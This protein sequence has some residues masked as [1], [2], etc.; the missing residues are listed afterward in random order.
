[1]SPVA[2]QGRYGDST[3]FK[4]IT[5]S[6]N[7]LKDIEHRTKFPSTARSLSWYRDQHAIWVLYASPK[8]INKWAVQIAKHGQPRPRKQ[9][10][11]AGHS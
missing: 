2:V 10:I 9:K 8:V 4:L 5:D 1:M 6:P 3:V 7:N 11:E